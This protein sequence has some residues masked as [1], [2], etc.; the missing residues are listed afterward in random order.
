MDILQYYNIEF[1]YEKIVT[2][3]DC[4]NDMLFM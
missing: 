2:Y 3:N 1:L 4:C